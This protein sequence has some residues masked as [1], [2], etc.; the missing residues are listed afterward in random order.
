MNIKNINKMDTKKYSMNSTSIRLILVMLFLIGIRNSFYSQVVINEVM[1]MPGTNY[2]SLGADNTNQA[3]QSLYNSSGTGSEWIE[4]YNSNSCQ[5][6]DL[7]CY[8]LGSITTSTNNATFQFPSGTIIPPLGFIIIGGANAPNVDFNLN[9]YINTPNLSGSSRWHLENGCGYMTLADPSGNII[10]AVYWSQNNSSDLSATN[11]C[12]GSFDNDQS[13]IVSSCNSSLINLPQARNILGIEYLGNFGASGQGTNVIGKSISRTLDGG[14]TWSLSSAGGTPRNCNGICQTASPFNINAQITQP[15][16][17]NPNGQIVSSPSPAGSYTY[18]WSHNAGLSLSNATALNSG[19]YT[20]SVSNGS[21]SKDTVI[22]LNASAPFNINATINQV[23]CALGD[24]QITL[25]PS[26]AGSYTYSWSH[27]GSLT[28]SFANNLNDGSYTITVDNGVCPKDTTI[29]LIPPTGCCTIPLTSTLDSIANSV[30]NASNNPCNYSGPTILINEINIYPTNG[31]GSIYGDGPT[32]PGS[33]EGEW[34]E[35][36]NPDWCN[37]IDI[38]GYI[39]GSYNSTSAINLSAS[40]GMGFVIPANTIVPPLGFVVVRG[41][42]APVPPI[43][44]IDIV[45]NNS[46]NQVCV[47]GGVSTNRIWFQNAGGWFAFYNQNGVPQD[48]IKWGTPPT[49]GDLNGNPC[50][51]TNNSLPVGFSQL[52]SCNSSGISYALGASSQGQT[53]VRIP[54]GGAWSTNLAA[55]NSTY[56]SCNVIGGCVN[57]GG[58]NSTCNGSAT[59]T[60]TSGQAPYT[61]LW[62]DVLAQKTSTAD[63]LCAGTYHVTVTDSQGC[64]EIFEVTVI[65]SLLS[66]SAN[67]TNPTCGN[68]DGQI[69][70]LTNPSGNYSYVWSSNANIANTITTSTST[71]NGGVYTITVSSSTCQRD[72]TITLTAFPIIT[73]VSVSSTEENCN[74]SDG[75]VTIGQVT[76]GT[77]GFQ[78]NF[79]NQGNSSNTSYSA[80]SSGT[81]S[82]LVTDLNNCNYSTQIVVNEIS[83]PTSFDYSLV[84]TECS[85]SIGE[86]NIMAVSGGAIPYEYSIG[87]QSYSANSVF[88]N[89]SAG[90]YNVSVKDNNNCVLDSTIIVQTNYSVSELVIPNV[91]TANN[92]DVN[93]I[94]SVSGACI[95][96][97]DC[98]ILNRWGEVVSSYD[99]I[100][101]YW[102][103][104]KAGDKLPDGVYFYIIKVTFLSDEVKDYQGNITLF[105][106]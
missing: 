26:P 41:I 63:S 52:A 10:D 33:G 27:N 77:A 50:I 68:S 75:S 81:Y 40:N 95:Q 15:S 61:Y 35:L 93:D 54:D 25:N 97:F 71:L 56:G 1:F 102:D 23:T 87:G 29:I 70:I 55:E 89:L 105:N 4:L 84:N 92:D 6:V 5:P 67:G 53:Y 90:I 103:G 47:D 38:S 44:T 19:S 104:T 45:I 3:L 72:T 22:V 7:S 80:L 60:M 43:G 16:C 20:L 83:G 64:S 48:V 62:D 18:S 91:L 9:N 24:G 32:G 49:P 58:A 42:N 21:C 69:S 12:G 86:I 73:N 65:D 106:N 31:D 36:F 101:G 17:G 2:S 66:I 13:I 94:W 46:N 57:Q 79:N 14:S 74:N 34:I 88:D 8:I 78:Y 28:A 98:K 96:S 37:P 30:C 51:P 82:V 100:S 39:L 11:S 85:K 99:D 59:I 76:G